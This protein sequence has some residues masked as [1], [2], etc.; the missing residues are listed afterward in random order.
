V[1][2]RLRARAADERGTTIAEVAVATMLIGIIAGVIMSSTTTMARTS[3][4]IEER[5]FGNTDLR[6]ALE[7]VERDLRA[8][9]PIVAIPPAQPVSRYRT[10][11]S[12]SIYC[13]DAGV[14]DCNS[15]NE[16]PVTYRL[17]GNTL[18]RVVGSR[19]QRLI[20]PSGPSALPP[21]KQQGAVVNS[22]GRS[23]F[24]YFDERGDEIETEGVAVPPSSH[25]HICTLS[26]QI[27]LVV[28]VEAG[29]VPV[30]DD[31]TTSG[32]LRNYR[33]R[34]VDGCV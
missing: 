5:S 30:T 22:G 33:T 27:D 12:F 32:T 31:L 26:M 11:V 18:E 25:F 17:T 34:E 28:V 3:A 14:G 10:E 19:V 7:I 13:A 2:G 21:E 20:G 16:R 15:R 9:N 1:I 6:T 24:R 8:A 4:R 29:D 23:V